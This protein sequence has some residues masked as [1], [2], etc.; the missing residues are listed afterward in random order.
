MK[1]I[2]RLTES[3]LSRIIKRVVNEQEDN[4]TNFCDAEIDKG[5]LDYHNKLKDDLKIMMDK[6]NTMDFDCDLDEAM[7]FNILFDPIYK[8]FDSLLQLNPKVDKT[9]YLNYLKN[10]YKF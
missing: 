3:D 4:D 2:V 6:Y 8:R 1:K 5:L 7:V 10:K 9:K